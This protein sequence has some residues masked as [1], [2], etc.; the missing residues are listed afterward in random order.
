MKQEAPIPHMM[1]QRASPA[2]CFPESDIRSITHLLGRMITAKGDH[3]SK[4]IRL[5]NGLAHLISA[6]AWACEFSDIDSD[7]RKRP[8]SCLKSGLKK[9]SATCQKFIPIISRDDFCVT[10]ALKNDTGLR[11]TNPSSC[12]TLRFKNQVPGGGLSTIGMF[13]NVSSRAFSERDGGV[14]ELVLSEVSWVH[15][16]HG[17]ERSDLATRSLSPRLRTI[18]RFLLKGNSRKQIA[19]LL[20]MELNT[21]H[22]Y[23]RDLYLV[24]Q[25]KSQVCLL[26]R[27][28]HDA[29]HSLNPS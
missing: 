4:R 28:A 12:H 22:G 11:F 15:T 7:E 10:S 13:K 16:P 24:F 19:D 23:V 29:V 26:R 3:T 5:L 20:G 18:L 2:L 1:L 25:V 14:F 17:P 9:R 8:L 27:C 6:D 21:V